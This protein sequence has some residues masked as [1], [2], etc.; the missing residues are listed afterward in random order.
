MTVGVK[1]NTLKLRRIIAGERAAIDR[2]V[3][4]AA[5]KIAD[6][7]QQLAPVD[8]GEL[9]DSIHVEEDPQP[10]FYRI[11]AS[12]PHAVY[13]EFGTHK[14]QAQPFLTPAAQRVSL[15]EEISVEMRALIR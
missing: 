12:A 11:V 14:M 9:R 2:G 10:G 13:V 1:L 15:L 6:L 8:T 7:A 5:G 3:Q 4:R